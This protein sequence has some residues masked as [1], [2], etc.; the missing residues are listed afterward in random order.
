MEYEDLST[1]STFRVWFP[2]TVT[3]NATDLQLGLVVPAHS[4]GDPDLGRG[5]DLQAV[6]DAYEDSSCAWHGGRFQQVCRR[7]TP[8]AQ[9]VSVILRFA[10]STVFSWVSC[11]AQPRISPL[12]RPRARS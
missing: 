7:C 6:Y 1:T 5:A 4:A 12:Q 9:R 3:L 8:H 11:V 2:T 10:F